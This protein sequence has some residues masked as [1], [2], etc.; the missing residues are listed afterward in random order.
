[1]K[2]NFSTQDK[3]VIALEAFKE[4]LTPGQIASKYEIHPQQVGRWKK[5]A[6]E[7][8]KSGFGDKRKKENWDQQRLLDELYKT[9][10][11]RDIEL[12]WLKKKLQPFGP[13]Q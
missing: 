1:M 13:P 8:L 2:K 9:I 6:L 10:G 5:E 7:I 4:E 11:Q 3:M 12:A